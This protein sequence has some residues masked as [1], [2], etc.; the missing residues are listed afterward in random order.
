MCHPGYA[1]SELMEGSSYTTARET[2]LQ[3]LTSD[4]IQTSIKENEISL[5][6]FSDL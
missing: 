3:I 6:R 2:E 1:D 4:K 5:A